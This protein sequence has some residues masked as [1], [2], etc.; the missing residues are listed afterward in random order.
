MLLS[1]IYEHPRDKYI[2]FKDRDE[3][4]KKIH[5]Y[6]VI[7]YNDETSNHNIDPTSVTTVAGK[8][9]P[10]F[11]R[12]E[13]ISNILGSKKMGDP[14]YKYYGM[15]REDIIKL[16]G[17]NNG[18]ELGTILHDRIELF[19]NCVL[20]PDQ[21]PDT[22][23]FQYFL[24]FFQDFET[25]FPGWRPYRT[26]WFVWTDVFKDNKMVV[27]AID[28]VF[29]NEQGELAIFDWKR[30]GKIKDV[31]KTWNKNLRTYTNKRMLGLLSHFEDSKYNHYC[32]QLNIYRY[33]LQTYYN[34]NVTML[35]LVVCHPENSK[36]ELLEVPMLDNEINS[37]FNE[38]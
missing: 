34:K 22:I 3:N 12:D 1:K 33:I 26:E 24:D 23:E 31:Q 29:I 2:V 15:T 8:Y 6:I 28:M 25:K 4:G 7:N 11:N 27:G 9:E 18:A 17:S 21:V 32:I 36:Y 37:I 19:Y 10:P 20:Q 5:K 14:E 38:I 35:Y 16:W 30:V 13:I